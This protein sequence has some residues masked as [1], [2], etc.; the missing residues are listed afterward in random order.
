MNMEISWIILVI[1]IVIF[2]VIGSFTIY[3]FTTTTT[4]KNNQTISPTVSPIT[5]PSSISVPSLQISSRPNAIRYTDCLD[6]TTVSANHVIHTIN[7]YNLQS[8]Y[9]PLIIAYAMIICLSKNCNNLD[10]YL[11]QL[12]L[13][14]ASPNDAST[15]AELAMYTQTTNT[16]SKRKD[17][18]VAS[19]DIIQSNMS[20]LVN[21]DT[22]SEQDRRLVRGF[23]YDFLRTYLDIINRS[24]IA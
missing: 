17:F 20:L 9:A 15:T 13:L 21:D 1:G 3:Y 8:K 18:L 19:L 14:G 4:I 10:K 16:P 24:C 11:E 5:S 6:E 22:I 12:I 23:N 7:K 2:C